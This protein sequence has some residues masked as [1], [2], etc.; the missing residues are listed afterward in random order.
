MQADVRER[1]RVTRIS[2]PGSQPYP[3]KLAEK[4]GQGYA[5]ATGGN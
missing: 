3:K 2:F 4:P 5:A 1:H